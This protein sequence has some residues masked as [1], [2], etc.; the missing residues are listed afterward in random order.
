MIV[1]HEFSVH[2]IQAVAFVSGEPVRPA[3][4]LLHVLRHYGEVY[5]GDPISIP[6][7]AD[8]PPEFPS[9]IL[10]SRDGSLRIDV[11]RTMVSLTWA[12]DTTSDSASLERIYAVF[13][14]RLTRIFEEVVDAGKS[15][16]GRIGAVVSR[17]AVIENPGRTLA[18][19]FCRDEMLGEQ[20]PLNRPEGFELHA[21]KVFELPSEVNVN[22]WMR[23]RS[24]QDAE[25][26]YR[27]VSVQQDMN[28]LAEESTQHN[29]VGR[30]L[31][32]ILSEMSMEF[33]IVLERYFPSRLQ[34]V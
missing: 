23:I 8:V 25:N 3:N 10:S 15:T 34:G 14:E 21:H 31:A 1:A 12:S 27:Y 2:S 32:T 19:Q 30:E 33:D 29:F 22:S 4:I 28:T 16:V 26:V 18:R 7:P 9:V 5:D 6:L 24:V 17:R 11:A 20:G 13:A